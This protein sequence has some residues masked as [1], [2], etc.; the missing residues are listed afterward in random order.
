MV[1]GRVDRRLLRGACGV[2]GTSINGGVLSLANPQLEDGYLRI[3]NEVWNQIMMC[4]F[5]REQ[6]GIIDLIIRLSWGC[7]KKWAYIPRQKDF[8]LAGVYES[9]VRRELD[10]LEKA[11]VIEIDRERAYFRFNKYYDEWRVSI[12]QGYDEDRL[13]SLVAENLQISKSDLTKK[14]DHAPENLQISKNELTYKEDPGA[15]NPHGDWPE[16]VSKDILKDN[17]YKDKGKDK[18]EGLSPLQQVCQFYEQHIGTYGPIQVDKLRS[19]LE[20]PERCMPAD[21]V[22]H[23]IEI[24]ADAGI[25]RISYIEGILRNWHNDGLRTLADIEDAGRAEDRR[26]ADG[27]KLFDEES[28]R[29][30]LEAEG[31]D[32]DELIS[33]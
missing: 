4:K 19:W 18:G 1:G 3:A 30:M 13:A 21:V 17:T 12:V 2:V 23:A 22:M 28:Y 5:N 16:A 24:A 26:P 11:N 29:E 25:R 9:H 33:S 20:D 6:R 8:C 14:E 10:W 27:R 7:G 32:Y 31:I 15:S